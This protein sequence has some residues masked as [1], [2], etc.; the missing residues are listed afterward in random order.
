[1]GIFAL[2]LPS[3]LL[4]DRLRRYTDPYD[5]EKAIREHSERSSQDEL[6]HDNSDDGHDRASHDVLTTNTP[7]RRIRRVYSNVTR[8]A[9]SEPA[10]ANNSS[11]DLAVSS[12]S[13]FARIKAYVWPSDQM[14]DI[15]G[16]VPNYRWTPIISGIVIPFS[17]LLEIPGLTERWYIRT[18]N[19]QT[20]ETKPNPAILEIG[21]AF[22]IACAL[23]ANISL[24]LRFLEKR[25][26]TVTLLCIVFLTSH[27]IINIIAVT[28]FGVEHRFD[29]GFTYGEAYWLTLCSTI[30]SSITNISLIVDLIRTP[31]FAKRGSGLTRKQ[32]ALMIIVIVLL[33]YVA[34]G[35]LI[36]SF[37]I[38][39]SFV[40]GLYFTVVSIET[41]GFGD[42]VPH[43]TGARVFICFYISIGVVNL[44][45]AIAMCRETILEGLEIGYRRRLRNVRQRRREARRFRRWEARWQRAVEFRLR[46]AGKP[47]YVPDEKPHVQKKDA[48]AH[49]LGLFPNG[50]KVP[51]FKRV[52]TTIKRTA[53][54]QSMESV[55]GGHRKQ[56]LN[57][58]ALTSAQL[59]EA[60]LEAGVPLEMFL[61][62]ED[63]QVDEPN[64]D[65]DQD[66][67]GLP[68]HAQP[69]GGTVP[70]LAQTHAVHAFHETIVSGWPAHPQTPTHAQVGRM[71]AMLTKF[72]IAV[73]G[74]HAHAPGL[75]RQASHH[76]HRHHS[77][78]DGPEL[79]HRA[80]SNVHS[81]ESQRQSHGLG[82]SF[83]DTRK[84]SSAR[85]LRDFSRGAHQ[86]STW[87][88]E[89]FRADMEA[90][91]KKA[92]YV[93]TAIAWLLFFLFWTIGSGIFCVT[94]GWSYGTAMY[95]CFV[96]FSTTGYGD[97]SPKTP[98]GRSV[99]VV[100]ALFGVG[101]LTILVSVLQEGGS[102]RYKSALHSRTFDNA[103]T[104]YR[105]N[106]LQEGKQRPR[107]VL[108]R[109]STTGAEKP[110]NG[111]ANGHQ[112]HA[113]PKAIG[114]RL[115]ESQEISQRALETL[116]GEII[117]MSREFHDYM[118]FLVSGR[119]DST[120]PLEGGDA[121]GENGNLRIPPDM[122]NLLDELCNME[123]IND[124]VRG[125]IL[126]DEDA[127]KTLFMLSLER[128]FKR[129][130]TSA[131]KAL[132]ALADRDAL[133]SITAAQ[134]PPQRHHSVFD[135]GSHADTPN[136]TDDD[137]PRDHIRAQSEPTLP[138]AYHQ[139]VR[140][141]RQAYTRKSPI[142]DLSPVGRLSR[143][144]SP[145]SPPRAYSP[146]I[147]EDMP[148]SSSSVKS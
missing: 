50:V 63:R 57:V 55:F 15:E 32:R 97:Y 43:S 10:H 27:D 16:F 129:L 71:S 76:G 116:P 48:S 127:R 49:L 73:A 89:K 122:R 68:G 1:M 29:D 106:Q 5:P 139:H 69:N 102:S 125:E 75:S 90:E 51:F 46:E 143:G 4:G 108:N 136:D 53:T 22:S 86:R 100:W 142:R 144:E 41:I 59:E 31:D 115:K 134:R 47:I 118:Q 21:L 36:N 109:P 107:P 56:H 33:V 117:R 96:A 83:M 112:P 145:A 38:D 88:Y 81:S 62:I 126:Q 119:A 52:G 84:H 121:D 64:G 111:S 85:W 25:V 74:S 34:L 18:E 26:Q 99:F 78:R 24:I 135:T 87:T 23:I 91:E 105:K 67:S 11:V 146:A 131:E 2:L 132:S 94:E 104:K 113:E 138:V 12:P 9:F 58:E 7:H 37:L 40:D 45:V 20:V 114:E 82:A 77:T 13:L 65:A 70:A 147:A 28:V 101:T 44:G 6:D 60:A 140:H 130:V 30:A 66:V 123:G 54:M 19:N 103:V 3:L 72:A 128:S 39:L 14:N 120:N 17:I 95:F 8:A 92:Y 137:D 98:A 79:P 42:I 35:A 124:R 133:A 80:S 93:K 141:A 61:N 110:A 148:S